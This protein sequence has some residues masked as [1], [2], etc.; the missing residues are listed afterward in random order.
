[1]GILCRMDVVARARQR[2]LDE[3]LN[4]DFVLD[5]QES[6]HSTLCC[7]LTAHNTIVMVLDGY[8]AD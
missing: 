1:M 8:L 7:A 2:L 4:L 3:A 5:E 6:H